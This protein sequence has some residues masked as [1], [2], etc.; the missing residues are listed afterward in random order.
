MTKDFLLKFLKISQKDIYI[1]K[2][3]PCT[4]FVLWMTV[5]LSITYVSKFT[6]E[7]KA[8]MRFISANGFLPICDRKN[9]IFF[10]SD[11]I[12]FLHVNNLS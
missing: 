1:K 12:Y 2:G 3:C 8:K 11:K 7:C 5:I 10:P 4:P 9:T 6:S